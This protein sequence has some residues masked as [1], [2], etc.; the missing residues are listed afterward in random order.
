MKALP[1]LLLGFAIL[2]LTACGGS[3]SSS[4][5]SESQNNNT[6][7]WPIDKA[8]VDCV[9][10]SANPVNW[11]VVLKGDAETLSE[12]SLFSN[13][14]NPTVAH[15]ERSLPYDLFTPLFTDYATKYRFVFIPEN[16]TINYNQ[17]EALDFPIGSVI[18]KTFTM[19][20]NTDNRVFKDELLIE[21]RLLIRQKDGWIARAYIWNESGTEAYRSRNGG[22]VSITN[23]TH[24]GKKMPAFTY[25]VPTQKECTDC[26]Q[27]IPNKG[28]PNVGKLEFRPI[29]PKARFLNSDYEYEKGVKENQLV[30]WETAGLL[31]GLPAIST[32]QKAIP[33][34]DGLELGDYG[35]DL[36]A[37]AKSWLD[38]NCA[39]CHRPEGQASN[40]RFHTDY[41]ID[42]DKNKNYHGV[43]QVPISGASAGSSKIIVPGKPDISLLYNRLHTTTP[44]LAMPPVG[45]SLIHTEGTALI[46]AWIESMDNTGLCQK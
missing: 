29:G 15:S 11:D 18:T 39:H 44:G 42:F 1:S 4:S 14:C 13:T 33:F 26:H 21:T 20:K 2:G 23:L 25:K 40:T 35:S 46:Y 27:F 32:V 3:S 36:T 37:T 45:R 16:E 9:D 5:A 31:T 38:I 22:D 17:E 24:D 6:K 43:C 12:Y 8:P 19:P 28:L 30:K 34:N 10:N 41:N 7:N